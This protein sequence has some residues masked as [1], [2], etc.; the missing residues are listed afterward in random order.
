MGSWRS[1]EA[2]VDL[3]R[4][5]F[6]AHDAETLPLEPPHADGEAHTRCR[7]LT[8]GTQQVGEDL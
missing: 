5:P 7:E 8:C 1:I 2:K 3:G 6:G 4:L